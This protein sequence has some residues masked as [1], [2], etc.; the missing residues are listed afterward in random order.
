MGKDWFSDH[1][2]PPF[3][4]SPHQPMV[5]KIGTSP[6]RSPFL[7]VQSSSTLIYPYSLDQF[8]YNFLSTL[9]QSNR[10]TIHPGWM[11]TSSSRGRP[12]RVVRHQGRRRVHRSGRY[13]P[14][15]SRWNLSSPTCQAFRLHMIFSCLVKS[16]HKII[17]FV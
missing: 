4:S 9:W 6:H 2:I 12:R 17:I 13:P 7:L 8:P 14:R 16:M 15:R 10:I 5:P 11:E 3:R 1:A